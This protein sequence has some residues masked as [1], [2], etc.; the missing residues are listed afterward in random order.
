M[1]LE[2]LPALDRCILWRRLITL[3]LQERVNSLSQRRNLL[4]G[5]PGPV[6]ERSLGEE[7]LPRGSLLPGPA[8]GPRA[9][10]GSGRSVE[11]RGAGRTA[12]GSLSLALRLARLQP[13]EDGG[14]GQC[15]LL[16]HSHTLCR[17]GMTSAV[18]RRG[19]SRRLTPSHRKG[20][21]EKDSKCPASPSD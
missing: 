16:K 20:R 12:L 19:E 8:L 11:R 7:T 10:H 13:A 1:R 15:R 18:L 3:E 21:E 4:T 2:L 17:K 5:A 6:W 9:T 14:Y